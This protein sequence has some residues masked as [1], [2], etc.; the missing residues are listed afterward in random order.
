M[1]LSTFSIAFV[2]LFSSSCSLFVDEYQVNSRKVIAY[3]LED[4]PLPDDADIIKHINKRIK[5][6]K[7]KIVKEQELRIAKEAL[8][9]NNQSLDKVETGTIKSNEEQTSNELNISSNTS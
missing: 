7:D 8:E 1:K 3:L 4:L 2:L 9:K 6:E 5:L